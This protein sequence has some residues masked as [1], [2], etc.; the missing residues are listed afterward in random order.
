LKPIE[1]QLKPI[2]IQLKP[3]EIQLKFNWNQL[4]FN[5]NQ[6]KFNWNQ[7]KL[8]SWLVCAPDLSQHFGIL[9]WPNADPWTWNSIDFEYNSFIIF[10]IS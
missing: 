8:T 10:S 4:K 2:E 5:W 1:I 6:L 9:D 3:I 7:L